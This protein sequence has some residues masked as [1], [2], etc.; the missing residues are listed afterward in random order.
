MVERNPGAQ[1]TESAKEWGE[2]LVPALHFG[3]TGPHAT[4]IEHFFYLYFAMTLLHALHLTIGIVAML[5]LAIAAV[6]VLLVAL[7]FMHLT[8]SSAVIRVYAVT[9]LFALGLLFGLTLT[10]YRT[11]DLHAAAYQQPHQTASQPPQL[12]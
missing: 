7:F 5:V 2:H 4:A 8:T 6:K 12:R 3:A 9:A 11:R 1:R 10:D